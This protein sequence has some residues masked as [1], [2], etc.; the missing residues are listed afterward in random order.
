MKTNKMIITGRA[1]IIL[2]DNID[3]DMIYPGRYLNITDKE[4]TKEHL[5]ELVYPKLRQEIKAGDIIIAAKNFGCGSSREQAASAITYANISAVIASSFARIF[6]R[7]GINLGLP[8]ITSEDAYQKINRG[9]ELEINLLEGWIV[10]KTTK[11][12]IMSASLDERAI[13]LL[14]KGGLIPYL[15]SK[16]ATI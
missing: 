13:T 16:Y 15:R 9:D 5:F 10:N 8:C 14:E 2:T 6:F 7:N 4:E 11:E 1:C 3:T 12:K